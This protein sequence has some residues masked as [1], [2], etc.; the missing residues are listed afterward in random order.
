ME[1]IDVDQYF[2]KME[3]LMDGDI[4]VFQRDEPDL[5]N[6]ELATAKDYFR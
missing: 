1:R 2:E 4:F 6:Y 3:E 5:E